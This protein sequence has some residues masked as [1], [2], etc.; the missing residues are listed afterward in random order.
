[1]HVQDKPGKADNFVLYAA[2][3]ANLGIAVA[4]FVAAAFTGS[5]AMLTEGIHSTVDSTNQ[6]LLL[7]GRK[8][9]RKAPDARHPLGYGREIYFWSFVVA[10]LIFAT[11]AGVSIYE[12]VKHI[13]EPEPATSIVWN[14]V[15]LGIAFLFEGYSWSVALREFGETRGDCGWV[16]A[17]RDSKDPPVFIVV[18]EDSAALFG[19]VTAGLGIT[20]SWLTGN[21]IWDGIA[22]IVIGCML[23][24]VAVFLARESRGL[25]IGEAADPRKVAALRRAIDGHPEIVEV[26][27][28]IT[29]HAAP[30]QVTGLASVDFDDSVPAGRIEQ[31]IA[32]IERDARQHWP[33]LRAL[34]V[35]PRSATAKAG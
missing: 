23:A 3:A 7:Y 5:S 34:Y 14:Y 17:I 29:I 22:S 30:D 15:V 8:M 31:L 4:K 9:S 11:G 1:M 21:P 35:K 25:L 32:E 12:G 27:E 2:L 18:L 26:L 20:L 33:E 16:E 6:L 10:I 28:I 13:V 24:F 19:I